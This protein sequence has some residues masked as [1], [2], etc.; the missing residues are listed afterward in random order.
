METSHHSSATSHI[1]GD[2]SNNTKKLLVSLNTR[3]VQPKGPSLRS[4]LS[5]VKE[6]LKGVKDK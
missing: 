6:G 1:E 2:H 3:Q 5:F 4:A